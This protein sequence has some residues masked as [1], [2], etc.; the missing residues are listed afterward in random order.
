M[1]PDCV[2]VC[3]WCLL[4]HGCTV[5]SWWYWSY[6]EQRWKWWCGILAA[7]L[8]I[9]L[10]GNF[11]EE[12]LHSLVSSGLTAIVHGSQKFLSLSITYITH[13][14]TYIST[15]PYIKG[16]QRT[17]TQTRA[18]WATHTNTATKNT[19]LIR[20]KINPYSTKSPSPLAL[21][22]PNSSATAWKSEWV[23]DSYSN[24]VVHDDPC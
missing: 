6:K 1:T 12:S 18:Q 16:K 21:N 17:E 22:S 13:S 10:S 3:I 5:W 8:H 11:R 4:V 20:E 23:N 19:R 7:H 14:H 15:F 24:F 9:K 2:Y